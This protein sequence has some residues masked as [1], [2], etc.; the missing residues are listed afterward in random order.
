[1]A[2]WQKSDWWLTRT[3]VRIAMLVGYFVGGV[4]VFEYVN[5][6]NHPLR[7]LFLFAAIILF[8][9]CT[10]GLVLSPMLPTWEDVA[11]HE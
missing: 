2:T 7:W 10:I 4:S 8:T 11:E 1:M 6:P 5:Q 3:G 9:L